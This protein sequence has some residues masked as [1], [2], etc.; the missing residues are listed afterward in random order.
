MKKQQILQ[1]AFS[2]SHGKNAYRRGTFSTLQVQ[3]TGT[4][5]V[6]NRDWK[7]EAPFI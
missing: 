5:K 2:S 6:L 1:T 4:I 3:R 7:E